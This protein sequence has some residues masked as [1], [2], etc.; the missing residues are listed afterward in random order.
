VGHYADLGLRQRDELL[1]EVSIG[2]SHSKNAPFE[3]SWANYSS[4]GAEYK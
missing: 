4:S 1:V 2:R 3:G